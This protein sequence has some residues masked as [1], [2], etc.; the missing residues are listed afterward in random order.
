MVDHGRDRRAGIDPDVR[1]DQAETLAAGSIRH[2]GEGFSPPPGL[3]RPWVSSSRRGQAIFYTSFQRW[4][5]EAAE[6]GLH[7]AGVLGSM[8]NT[9]I[10]RTRPAIAD[11][12]TV[13]P[14]VNS[15]IAT[16][17]RLAPETPGPSELGPR[18][19]RK[20]L[21]TASGEG[22]KQSPSKASSHENTTSLRSILPLSR[23]GPGPRRAPSGLAH[24]PGGVH[25]VVCRRYGVGPDPHVHGLST[26]HS[27]NRR[28]RAL[29]LGGAAGLAGI[30]RFPGDGL[31][32]HLDLRAH[33]LRLQATPPESRPI[34]QE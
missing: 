29:F 12:R 25:R 28:A 21:T 4:I 14:I 18:D 30:S 22:V 11:K 6:A 27:R 3:R 7:E 19:P 31:R 23:P 34:G 8:L 9:A 16:F 10:L 26:L 15:G 33:R 17:A 32:A 20:S 24:D 1:V 13:G 2:F 5:W